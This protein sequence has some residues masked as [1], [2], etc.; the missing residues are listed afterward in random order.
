MLGKVGAAAAAALVLACAGMTTPGLGFAATSEPSPSPT[1]TCTA[2]RANSLRISADE[3]TAGNAPTAT[4]DRHDICANEQAVEDVVIFAKPANGEEYVAARGQTQDG[5]FTTVIRPIVSTTYRAT[6]NGRTVQVL[7]PEVRVH[8]RVSLTATSGRAGV[9]VTG[10]L[11]P[12]YGGKPVGVA[13]VV[14]GRWLYRGQARTDGAGRFTSTV[15][16]SRGQHALVVY[17]SQTPYNLKGSASRSVTV[18]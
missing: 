17:T 14:N 6:S 5:R 1:P 8:I 4:V 11:V 2:P 10:Q 13:E 15:S 7:T 3:I 18:P 16:A 9:T 12:Q